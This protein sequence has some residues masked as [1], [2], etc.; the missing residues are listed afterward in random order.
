M[1][2]NG[3]AAT[4]IERLSEGLILIDADG[5]P[6]YANPAARA[7]FMVDAAAGE[8]TVMQ[9]LG[10]VVDGYADVIARTRQAGTT[11]SDLRRLKVRRQA[12]VLDLKTV[13]L[14]DGALA[15]TFRDASEEV[16]WRHMMKTALQQNTEMVRAIAE[17]VPV[18]LSVT[19]SK[20]RFVAINSRLC[21]MLGYNAR[22]LVNQSFTITVP[23][24]KRQD[25][26]KKYHFAMAGLDERSHDARHTEDVLQ[27]DGSVVHYAV[28]A[29]S[30]MGRNGRPYRVT[31][32]QE[33]DAG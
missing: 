19:D 11:Q 32:Y 28:T 25:M 21:S 15:M 14:D 17:T 20:G 6:T 22:D 5:K 27:K 29:T 24:D 33:P 4:V 23:E 12:L 9:E 3:V 26:A 16:N 13:L 2:L 31:C 10:L 8:D 30:F 18:G 1:A 7:L